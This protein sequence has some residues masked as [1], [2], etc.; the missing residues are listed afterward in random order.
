MVLYIYVKLYENISTVFNLQSGHEN[1][2]EMVIF[3][4][5]RAITP[6]LGNLK[7]VV[8]LCFTFV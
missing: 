2:V 7:H 6:E 3:N 5:K 4:V 1:M 8:S